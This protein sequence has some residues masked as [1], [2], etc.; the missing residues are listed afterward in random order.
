MRNEPSRPNRLLAKDRSDELPSARAYR[1]PSA[2]YTATA[3]AVAA[4][5]R[6]AV[7]G[8]A[9][10]VIRPQR[11]P[12][13]AEEEEDDLNKRSLSFS[14]AN[15]TL[16]INSFLKTTVD[17]GTVPALVAAGEGEQKAG[18]KEQF[19]KSICTLKEQLESL[20]NDIQQRIEVEE[21]TD[22]HVLNQSGVSGN[23]SPS[24]PAPVGSDRKA[25]SIHV[26]NDELEENPPDQAP[27][28]APKLAPP[29]I[30]ITQYET[31]GERVDT[32]AAERRSTYNIAAA[33]Q[34]PRTVATER[35]S[36]GSKKTPAEGET[37][38]LAQRLD[39]ARAEAIAARAVYLSG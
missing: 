30:R 15:E 21:Y 5:S 17:R 37:R 39:E 4:S 8:G 22:H 18:A 19:N 3:R 12:R 20:K 14:A 2:V 38:L 35:V 10:T 26:S 34:K 9:T 16:P 1:S 29:A 23:P 25:D 28:A 24:V 33:S 6:P 13:V 36:S 11:Y 31:P 27:V 7:A 32:G